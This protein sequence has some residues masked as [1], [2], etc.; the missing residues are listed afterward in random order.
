M[1]LSKPKIC[2]KALE[3]MRLRVK[4]RPWN[5]VKLEEDGLWESKNDCPGL[6][7]NPA[8]P[9]KKSPAKTDG[10]KLATPMAEPP[11]H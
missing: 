3:Q 2:P 9:P 7:L 10:G 8:A 5:E 6:G 11:I 4:N 1:P